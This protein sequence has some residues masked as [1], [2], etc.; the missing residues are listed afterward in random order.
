MQ[1]QP[2]QQR[3]W[4]KGQAAWKTVTHAL[5]R[6][7]N[8]ISDKSYLLIICDPEAS[9]DFPLVTNICYKTHTPVPPRG[10]AVQREVWAGFLSALL[11]THPSGAGSLPGHV[12]FWNSLLSVSIVCSQTV[13]RLEIHSLMSVREETENGRAQGLGSRQRGSVTGKVSPLGQSLPQCKATS[14]HVSSHTC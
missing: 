1:A 4:A 10:E 14:I 13:P 7:G 11:S 6:T 3:G 5:A 2:P 12:S 8:I 9:Q